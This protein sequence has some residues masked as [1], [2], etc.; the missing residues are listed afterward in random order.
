MLQLHVKLGTDILQRQ[1]RKKI[2]K[3]WKE[4][5]ADWRAGFFIHH[6]SFAVEVVAETGKAK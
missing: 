5:T 1:S 2:H 4:E 6:K 3:L